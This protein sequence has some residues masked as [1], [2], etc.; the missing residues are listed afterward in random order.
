MECIVELAKTTIPRFAI[1]A[2]GYERR[3]SSWAFN[4][5]KEIRVENDCCVVFGFEDFKNTLSRNYND[6]Y[7]RQ[8]GIV[9]FANSTIHSI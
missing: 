5:F 9:V 8:N 7:Y 6:E 3:S 4:T 2:S 1:V